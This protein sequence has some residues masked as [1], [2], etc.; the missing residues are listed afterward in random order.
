[1]RDGAIYHQTETF[2]RRPAAA[3]WM[4][5][6]EC[7][8]AKSGTIDEIRVADPRLAKIIDTQGAIKE[9]GR[10]KAQVLRAIGD[11]LSRTQQAAG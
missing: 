3:V 1:M 11:R 4:R 6:R 8:L 7:E 9:I 2:D 10:S 5:K